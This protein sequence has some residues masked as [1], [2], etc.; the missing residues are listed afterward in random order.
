MNQRLVRVLCDE[1]REAFEP[2][3]ATLKKLNLP[4]DKIDRFYRPP[5]E[6]KLD[7]KG[8]EILCLTCQGTGYVGRTGVFELLV[9]DEGVTKLIEAGAPIDRIKAHSRKNRMYYLQETGLLKVID[10]RTSMNEILRCLRT[11][12]K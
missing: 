12:E 4:A 8:R 1:C 11:S 9:V 6:K 3:A 5:T 7:R 10:G 2:D